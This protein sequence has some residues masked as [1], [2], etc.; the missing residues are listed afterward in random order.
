MKRDIF[1]SIN[2][3]LK[4][5]REL[6]LQTSQKIK[7]T[8]PSARRKRAYRPILVAAAIL[9]CLS[10]TVSASANFSPSV[11]SLMYDV[12]PEIAQF[13]SPVRKSCEDNG[14][15]MEVISAYIHEGTAEVYIS[16]Q[17]LTEDRIDESIDLFD[18]CDI[19]SYFDISGHCERIGYDAD[20][21]TATFLITVTQHKNGKEVDLRGQKIHFSVQE[22]LSRKNE[23]N[24]VPV[25]FDLANAEPVTKACKLDSSGMEWKSGVYYK[26]G[27]TMNMKDSET[28]VIVPPGNTL[29]TVN[30]TQITAVAYYN[31]K[32]RVQVM[33]AHR[34][35]KDAHEWIYLK[36]KNG[37]TVHPYGTVDFRTYEDGAQIIGRDYIFDIPQDE[38][39]NYKLYGDFITNEMLTQGNWK[40]SFH[41][42]D[43]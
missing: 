38:I 15:K 2:G 37:E 9:V 10:V 17:D 28:N 31:G 6:I 7:N 42:E 33:T 34:L 27:A 19:R 13:F 43:Q 21:K 35:D 39:Q 14:I 30:D 32:L 11:Y 18:S 23:Q 16:M 1:D 40:V 26:G 41:L 5:D 4:P 24:N 36:D 22:F 8:V 20:S 12:S 25:A 3:K 29:C